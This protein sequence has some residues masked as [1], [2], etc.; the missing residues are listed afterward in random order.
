MRSIRRLRGYPGYVGD[1]F[2]YLRSPGA[3]PWSSISL[4]PMLEDK[5]STTGFDAHYV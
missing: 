4:R 3:K 1:L 5:T 2:R